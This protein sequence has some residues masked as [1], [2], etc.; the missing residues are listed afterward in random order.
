MDLVV[1]YV[2]QNTIFGVFKWVQSKVMSLKL[3]V[4]LFWGYWKYWQNISK[5][6][7]IFFHSFYCINRLNVIRKQIENGTSP[8]FEYFFTNI[9]NLLKKKSDWNRI[10][11]FKI[12]NL[13]IIYF[14]LNRKRG[15]ITRKVFSP[16]RKS[17][18][19]YT[20]EPT[21]L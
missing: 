7:S 14:V 2:Y 17:A 12:Q 21:Y 6:S 13:P 5:S 15:L 10:I 9:Y 16:R 19:L 8:V 18:I 4:K 3:T 1:N 11:K 20:L